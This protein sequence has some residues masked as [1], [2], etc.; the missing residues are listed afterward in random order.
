MSHT[1][2]PWKYDERP[3]I[4][5]VYAGE[6]KNCLDLPHDCFLFVR[7]F[8][9]QKEGWKVDLQACADA[10]LIAAAP[11]LLAAAQGALRGLDRIAEA[12]T[13][14]ITLEKADFLFIHALH[15]AIR[16]ATD[17]EAKA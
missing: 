5:A 9:R 13:G 10:R 15:A 17:P 3:G 8:A 7:G 11:D 16:K 4:V 14:R 6:E 2:G 1:P 12:M